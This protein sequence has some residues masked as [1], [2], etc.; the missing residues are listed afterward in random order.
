MRKN[1]AGGSY[2]SFQS[3]NK[4]GITKTVEYWHENKYRTSGTEWRPQKQTHVYTVQLTYYKGA[5]DSQW[6]SGSLFNNNAGKTDSAHSK[7]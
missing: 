2:S 1:K 5:K 7:E 4:A 3:L 6:G